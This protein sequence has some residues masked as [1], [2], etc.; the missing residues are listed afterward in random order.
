MVAVQPS[1]FTESKDNMA[2]TYEKI[3]TTTLGSANNSI[4]FSSIPSTYTDLRVVIAPKAAATVYYMACQ[5]NGDTA[6]NYSFTSLYGDGS[7]A[8][9]SRNTS[10]TE[11]GII[12]FNGATTT[13]PAFATIDVFSY[14]G[15]T[16][17]TIL[18]T[19]SADNNGS[20]TVERNVGL[21]RSTSAIT[22][23]KLFDTSVGRQMAT[24][25]TATLY[26]ILKA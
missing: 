12:W 23:I 21:W 10:Q 7:S 2:T 9:S 3:A 14:A 5:F 25:T 13:I 24:G 19:N 6:T 22:S 15:S 8:V 11:I 18:G 20:G 16:F 4:T 17:K 26:G 1:P